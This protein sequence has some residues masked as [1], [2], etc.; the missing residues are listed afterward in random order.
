VFLRRPSIS[1][2]AR[3]RNN[4]ALLELAPPVL[5]RALD[6][7][8][9]QYRLSTLSHLASIEFLRQRQQ[10]V[11]QA[12]YDERLIPGARFIFRCMVLEPHPAETDMLSPE[13][14]KGTHRAD[15]SLNPSKRRGEFIDGVRVRRR[16]ARSP[17][18]PYRA[19]SPGAQ[20]R[21]RKPRPNDKRTSLPAQR[22]VAFGLAAKSKKRS[23]CPIS[24]KPGSHIRLRT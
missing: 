23:R 5:A 10:R 14:T 4:V 24:I 6:L 16:H 12:S 13:F 17:A 2:A 15:R 22:Q 11:E 7:F 20:A 3:K 9:L 18:G 21:Y 1:G 8:R 19:P